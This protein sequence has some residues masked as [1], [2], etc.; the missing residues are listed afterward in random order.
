MML[1]L[2]SYPTM[3]Y[4]CR[5]PS[6]ILGFADPSTPHPIV[7][8]LDDCQLQFVQDEAIYLP[9]QFSLQF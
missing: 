9:H 4:N 5:I 2:R 3:F 7:L 8:L 1:N 6:E